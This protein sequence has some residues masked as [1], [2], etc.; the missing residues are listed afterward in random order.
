MSLTFV[1]L[2]S[3][4]HTSVDVQPTP[5]LQFHSAALHCTCCCKQ[6]A[7]HGNELP[8]FIVIRCSSEASGSHVSACVNVRSHS[9][10]CVYDHTAGQ[11]KL[12]TSPSVEHSEQ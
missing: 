12:I 11:Y 1:K 10:R 9:V 8:S 4:T 5:P 7:D 3:D 2:V 6:T